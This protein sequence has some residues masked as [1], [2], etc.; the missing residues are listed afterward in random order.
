MDAASVSLS[1]CAQ[2]AWSKTVFFA[3]LN[4]KRG[5]MELAQSAGRTVPMIT[6]T[7][8]HSVPSQTLTEEEQDP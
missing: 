5:T 7:T 8:V 4:V 6:E 1:L 2:R 3:T